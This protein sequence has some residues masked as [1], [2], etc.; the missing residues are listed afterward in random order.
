MEEMIRPGEKTALVISD[1]TRQWQRPDLTAAA[2]LSRL[3]RAGLPDR[4]IFLVIAA[5][6]HRLLED[7]EIRQ[8]VGHEIHDRFAVYNHDCDDNDQL[9]FAGEDLSGRPVHFNRRVMEADRRIV[10]GGIQFHNLAGFSGGRKAV[11]PG[12]AARETIQANHALAFD[13]E[14]GLRAGV[15]KG[16]LAGNPVAQ[17][18]DHGAR[19]LGVD[20]SV[21]VVVDGE[22]RFI[23]VSAGNVFEA[24]EQ[25]CAAAGRAS[26]AP[27]RK[28]ADLILANVGGYPRDVELYQSMKAL[29]HAVIAA[30][31]G[32]VIVLSS[33]C[34][35]GLG[36]QA[37]HDWIL[38]GSRHI[39]RSLGKRF[40]F[41][42]FVA[43]KLMDFVR[44]FRIG[45]LSSLEPSLVE[46]LGL[47]PLGSMEEAVAWAEEQRPQPGHVIFMPAAGTT[48]PSGP[49]YNNK[50]E[51]IK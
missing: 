22:G 30:E 36:S 6:M 46:P 45:L 47:H 49:I 29:D 27:F 40:D 14:S 18:M 4:D 43:L 32:A 26:L 5:G 16:L 31:E 15:G 20:F 42:G 44:R 11:L 50:Q 19:L 24:Q 12:I 51:R 13:D 28:K 37:W 35:D 41:P 2:V 8:L 21:N 23:H 9:S 7:H 1:R 33:F 39:A 34:A 38:Q 25:G 17:A 3:S 10:T 48:V